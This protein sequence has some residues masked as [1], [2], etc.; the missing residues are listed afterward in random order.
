M[1][2]YINK[3]KLLGTNRE[4]TLKPGLNIIT[5]SITT[6]KTT[7][8]KCFRGLLG[9]VLK[10][11]S[12]EARENIT[13]LAGEI[14]IGNNVYDIIR[15]FITTND[16]IVSI[17]GENEAKRLPALRGKQDEETYGTWL[18]GKLGLPT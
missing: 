18:L 5:G 4:F 11:F 7:L 9:T 14:F 15:P 17:A 16:A 3:I 8:I 10:D 1:R 12:K 6:G 13:C 2:I